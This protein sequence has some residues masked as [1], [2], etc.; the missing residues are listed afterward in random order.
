MW[1]LD[2]KESWALKNWCFWTT[3]LEK[4]LKSPLNSKEIE[5]VNPKGNQFW[6]VIGRTDAEVEASVIWPP[7]VRIRLIRKDLDAGKNWRWEEKGMTEDEMVGWHHQLNGHEFEQALGDGEGQG[8]LACCCPQ[9]HKES[10]M[11]EWMNNKG[12]LCKL[13]NTENRALKTQHSLTSKNDPS[14]RYVLQK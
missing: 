4:T 11:T 10:D 6:I 5:S 2:Y 14:R 12:H 3:V 7:N 9:G 13:I 8:G 1:E